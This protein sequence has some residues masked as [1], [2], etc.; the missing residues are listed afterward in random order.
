MPSPDAPTT[1]ILVLGAPR[2]TL[3]AVADTA[4]DVELLPDLGAVLAR[5]S[6]TASSVQ[7]VVLAGGLE[8]PLAAAR[9]IREVDAS[10]GL[11]LAVPRA[12][13]TATRG[14]LGLAPELAGALVVGDDGAEDE[15]TAELRGAA[16]QV[17]QQRQLRR[18]LDAM[19]RGLGAAPDPEDTP[20]APSVSERYLAAL[21]RHLPEGVVSVDASGDV[22]TMNP[23]ATAVLGVAREDGE[24]HPLAS[25]LITEEPDLVASLLAGA[26]AG[27]TA[28]RAAVPARRPDGERVL[29]DL[30]AAPVTDGRGRVA[31]TV[32][33]LRDVTEERRT[34]ERLRQLQKAESLATLAGG[35]AHDFNN[36]LV[37]VRSWAD[38]AAEDV[39]DAELVTTALTH[40]G[41]ASR[42]AAEL[43]RSM[44]AYAG[45]GTFELEPTDLN[46]VVEEMAGLLTAAI[47]RK[48]DVALDLTRPLPTV[49]A[50][51][52]QVRQVVMNLVTNASEAI[53][54]EAGSITV[55]TASVTI[56]A[57]R[58]GGD[59]EPVLGP[60]TYVLVE[61]RDSGIGMD[62]DTISRVFD[63]F[64]TTKFTGRGL[65]L[66]A[67]HG[68]VRAHGGDIEVASRPG[69]GADFRVLL[70]AEPPA[71]REPTAAGGP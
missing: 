22:V 20:A 59:D 29:L 23:S 66:A 34:E 19:N 2:G 33:L 46:E 36:L 68:I 25:L 37:S 5:L 53:G 58:A 45:H 64:F 48:T 17:V 38:M 13:L 40:I 24:G 51:A 14:R 55:R 1:P 16:D 6:A 56:A 67:S 54:D 35:V 32:F 41:R 12:E 49:L 63:P 9:R 3:A 61:V 31:G 70:P 8:R 7:L 18:A 52:T 71:S 4:P 11:A 21:T 60:G 10:I 27:G 57:D 30:T 28:E 62:E 50:D 69:R 47:S 15:L 44:L 26:A 65:G 43:A 42:R 39:T